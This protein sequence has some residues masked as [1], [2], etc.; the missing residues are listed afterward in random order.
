MQGVSERPYSRVY[1][2][3]R[4]DDRF[5]GIYTDNNHLATWLRLLIAADMAW[6]AP[7]DLPASA[8]RVS[9]AA[10]SDAGLVELLPG[11]LFRVHGLD[12]ERNER[13]QKARDSVMHRYNDR[14]TTVERPN[15]ERPTS[16]AKPSQ[17]EPSQAEQGAHDPANTYWDVTGKFPTDKTLV[18]ID[19]LASQYGADAVT[20]HLAA[21]SQ[22]DRSV[23]T[24]M[25]RVRDSLKAQ[26]R[27]LDRK[28]RAIEEQRVQANQKARA[29]SQLVISKHN[30]G[31][32]E[33]TPVDGCPYCS[34]SAA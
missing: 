6:P 13:S 2:E 18:W 3:V 25:G 32:H 11:H 1:W 28:D 5:V 27:A 9:L 21:R 17:D 24:L 22:E 10:L 30:A 4:A 23:Q 34:R 29:V 20:E 16:Q 8:R 15:Y 7:A 19:D 14:T 31:Q 12:R 33:S 26:A